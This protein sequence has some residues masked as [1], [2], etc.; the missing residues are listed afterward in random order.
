M[1]DLT[2][3][4]TAKQKTD[5]AALAERQASNAANQSYLDATDWLVM[6]QLETKK[7][8]PADITAKRQLARAGIVKS[9]VA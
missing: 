8:M 7:A 5:A 4:V 2:K 6:R 3:L 1:I 9:E